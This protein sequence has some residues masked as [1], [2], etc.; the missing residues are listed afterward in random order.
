[1]TV[2]SEGREEQ[3]EKSV[4]RRRRRRPSEGQ[5]QG[6]GQGPQER[7]G[8]FTNRAVEKGREMFKGGG[9]KERERGT[10]ESAISDD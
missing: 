6:Q 7:R 3:R 2:D 1:M 8:S 10:G 9:K 5:G 4:E